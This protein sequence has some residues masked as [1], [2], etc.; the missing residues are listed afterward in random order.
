[1]NCF[2]DIP[3][4]PEVKYSLIMHLH[5]SKTSKLFC[6]VNLKFSAFI[7]SYTNKPNK[8]SNELFFTNIINDMNRFQLTSPSLYVN[9]GCSFLSNKY[10]KAML[11]FLLFI[12][13]ALNS[14]S[15]TFAFFHCT[16]DQLL[17]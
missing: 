14:S 2:N 10:S 3:H 6:E 17:P 11:F 13:S 5:F 7:T 16:Y 15:V 1:M 12:I 4:F 8:K 9:A